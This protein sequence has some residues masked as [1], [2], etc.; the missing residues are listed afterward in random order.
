MATLLAVNNYFYRRGGAEAVFLEHNAMLARAGWRVVPFAMQH[1]RNLDSPW[2]EYFVDEIEFGADYTLAA[3]LVRV[4]K[5]VYSLEA[6][7]RLGELLDR[8]RPDACHAHN[9]YHHLSPSILGLLHD[10]GVPTVLTLHDLKIACPAYTMLSRGTICERCRGGRIHNVLVHRCIKGSLALSAIAMVE[11]AVHSMLGS[12]DRVSR[13]VVPSRFYAT[14]LVEWGVPPERFRHVPNF[15]DAAACEPR[16][17]PGDAF[18][19]FG[20]LAPEKGLA[21]LVRAAAL[22]AVPVVL[23]GTGP[24]AA[25][26][27]RLA[28]ACGARVRFTGHL[29]GAALQSMIREARAVVLPSEWYENAPLSVLEAYAHGKAVLGA[30]IGGIPELIRDGE[31]GTTF[32][33]GDVDELAARL[34]EYAALP[35]ATIAAQGAAAREYVAAEFSLER[36]RDRI[37][38]LYREIGVPG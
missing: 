16:Y 30:R 18:L 5:V 2:S 12:Y 4:P 26:L 20:R 31:T 13:F 24:E 28:Q 34:R 11:A 36:Y 27:E 17:A 8:V 33:S 15:V 21:T 9:I 38:S 32:T 6:R 3:K 7:R 22:A 19:Y 10:R 35:D 25:Q 23:A 1:P 29:A 37:L 14:K